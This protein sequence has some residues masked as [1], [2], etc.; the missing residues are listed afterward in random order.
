MK[1]PPPVRRTLRDVLTAVVVIAAAIFLVG[2]L[3]GC[4][5]HQQQAA[6]AVG[7]VHELAFSSRDHA[8]KIQEY[9]L[10]EEYAG[11]LIAGHAAQ[12]ID[13]QTEI[14]EL[15]N[16]VQ[17]KH[18]P[19]LKDEKPMWATLTER[20]LGLGLIVTVVG[21]LAY[22]GVLPAIRAVVAGVVGL[23]PRAISVIPSRTRSAAKLQAEA[24]AEGDLSKLG[25]AVAVQ[26]EN[27]L[28]NVAYRRF[29]P[30]E[31]TAQ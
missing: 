28:F 15:A 29:K 12:I 14:I 7:K 26:R 22:L 1:Y 6:E 18:L 3:A 5:T 17:T 13:E 8:Q 31:Q 16:Q 19:N 21:V 11:P 10:S 25:Q 4:K 30:E 24:L 9:A 27:P 20:A 2:A 23:I